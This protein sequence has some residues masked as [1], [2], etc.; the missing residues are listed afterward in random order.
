MDIIKIDQNRKEKIL[1]FQIEFQPSGI[2]LLCNE[3]ITVLDAARQT[4]IGLRAD[5]GGKGVCGKCRIQIMA[6]QDHLKYSWAELQH[7]NEE[8]RAQGVHLACELVVDKDLKVYVLAESMPGGQILQVEGMPQ[9]Y[10]NDAAVQQ[11]MLELPHASLHDLRSDVTRIKDAARN[12]A[13]QF[14]IQMLEVVPELV[15]DNEWHINLIMRQNHVMHVTRKPVDPLLGLAVDVGSTKIACFLMDIGKGELL[16]AQGT[17]NPQIA[18]GEDIMTR[19][20]FAVQGEDKAGLLHDQLITAINETAA[21]LCAQ[22]GCSAADIAD[23]CLVGNTAMHHFFLGLPQGTLAVSPFTPVLSEACYASAAS[24]GLDGMPSSGVYAPAV[25]A[26]FVGSDHLAFLLSC[27]FGTMKGT[28]LAIDIGTNTEIALMKDGD[29]MSVSTASGPAFEGAHIKHGMR[30]GPGAIEHVK[31]EA[32][33]C[34]TLDVIGGQPPIGLCGSGILDAVAE[35]RRV[36]WLNARGRL[37]R[38]IAQVHSDADDSLSIVLAEGEREITLSQK[39]IDQLLLAKGAIRAGI[40]VLMDALKVGADEID[41]VVIAGAFGSYMLPEQAV[42]LGMLPQIPLSKVRSVGNAAGAGA[43]MMLTSQQ[44]R[45]EADALA[46]CIEFL[47]LT[48]YPD[49]PLFFANG[50]R[51]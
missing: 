43:R 30:A 9:A 41:E 21:R 49:F 37:T 48:V 23:F 16:A 34:I 8:A 12:P 42:R 15:R 1:S 14:P 24:L 29:I 50:I 22:I 28:Q 7:L 36:G 27:G 18:Y 47:E 44:A 32:D 26:G 2:R 31:I 35:L 5:C 19:L 51:A 20:A 4:G 40:D 13:L 38:D 45:E 11:T 39:D 25:I 46:K 6:D 3:A 10:R 33:G 17:P